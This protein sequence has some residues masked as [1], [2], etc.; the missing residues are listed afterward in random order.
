[1]PSSCARASGA[2]ESA[3]GRPSRRGQR[4]RR[5]VRPSMTSADPQLMLSFILLR[6]W[7]A[8]CFGRVHEEVVPPG[9][10]SLYSVA[11]HKTHEEV[12]PPDLLT[13]KR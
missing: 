4:G 11:F 12:V 2:G 6:D 10:P 1:M 13:T 7:R 9:A 5:G 3:E 8:L